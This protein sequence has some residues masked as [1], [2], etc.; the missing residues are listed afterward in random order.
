MGYG[1]PHAAFFAT[2]RRRTSARCPAGSSASRKDARRPARRYRMALQTREQHIR[3]E[4]ATSN[5]CTAQVLLAVMAS[6]YA[7]YHGPEGLARDR[8]ARA[9]AARVLLAR[10]AAAA[11]LHASAHE[12]FFDTLR[13]EV[14][15]R[16]PADDRSTRAA[17]RRINLRRSR[18]RAPSASR[19]TRP[20]TL[21]DVADAARGVRGDE[22]LPFTLDELGRGGR[23]DYPAALAR[24]SAVPHAPGLQ[25]LPL[26]DRDAALPAA[27]R[28]ARPVARPRR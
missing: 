4:K 12:P 17:A 3:R 8:R 18:R 22:A 14:P 23:R 19:S 28:G 25:P 1:G 11:R 7:V 21:G 15:A 2:Q 24:T 26:R 20:T 9:R 6:M 16:A 13:V 10:G 27:A 5:I